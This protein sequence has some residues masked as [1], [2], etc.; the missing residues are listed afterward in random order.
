VFVEED[1]MSDR[2]CPL[3]FLMIAVFATGLVWAYKLLGVFLLP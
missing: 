3:G 2:A 1:V